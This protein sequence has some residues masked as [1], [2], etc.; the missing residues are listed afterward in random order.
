MSPI[1]PV[2]GDRAPCPPVRGG[3][4]HRARAHHAQAS[5]LR[6]PDWLTATH[7]GRDLPP[8]TGASGTNPGIAFLIVMSFGRAIVREAP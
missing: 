8:V 2:A 3:L 1:E 7:V 6:Q 4:A 5:G